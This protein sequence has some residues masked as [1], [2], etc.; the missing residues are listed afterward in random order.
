M[1]EHLGPR[2][3]LAILGLALLALALVLWYEGAFNPPQIYPV[4]L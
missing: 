4:G 1:V 2:G 3:L